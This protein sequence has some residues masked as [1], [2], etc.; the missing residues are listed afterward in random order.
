M[1]VTELDW[2]T[3]SATWAAL[4]GSLLAAIREKYY[5]E[6]ATVFLVSFAVAVFFVPWLL[7]VVGVKSPLGVQ[8]FMFLAGWQGKRISEPILRR[9]EKVAPDL[10]EDALR[11]RLDGD[12]RDGEPKE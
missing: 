4:V 9:I 7:D 11:R 6:K 8:A 12:R 3:D 5:V 2:K 10:F 1:K